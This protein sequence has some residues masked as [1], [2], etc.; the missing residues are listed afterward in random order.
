[1]NSRSHRISWILFVAVGAATIAASLLSLRAAY[2]SPDYD[3]I[4]GRFTPAEVANG[5]SE[6]AAA[7][8]ARRGT[9]AAF[10]LSYGILLIGM[11]WGPYRHRGKLLPWLS[12]AVLLNA[13]FV[14]LRV[15]VLGVG[16]GVPA[17][18]FPLVLGLTAAILG[19]RA[20]R[21]G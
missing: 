7:L 1:M 16:H 8:S 19:F 17:G 2:L 6:V 21:S 11:A 15:P 14:L 12:A 20:R 13:V 5:D 10:G 3:L 4:A 9:A 18:L